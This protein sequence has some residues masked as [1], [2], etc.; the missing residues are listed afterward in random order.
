MPPRSGPG[1]LPSPSI[2]GGPVARVLRPVPVRLP[3]G[4]AGSMTTSTAPHGKI[5]LAYEMEGAPQGVPLLLIMGLGLSM[6]FWPEGFR[7]LLVERGFRV[8][9]FD[10]RDVGRSTHL[11]G[12]GAPSALSLLTRRRPA[13]TLA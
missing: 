8:A 3:A 9:R 7:A 10:N 11:S 13:Y 12:L 2:G 6:D 4:H 1:L 5:S